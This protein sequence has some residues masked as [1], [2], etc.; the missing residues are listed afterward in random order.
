MAAL[1]VLSRRLL[2]AA[3]SPTNKSTVTSAL[4]PLGDLEWNMYSAPW[5]HLVLI[6]K[7][8]EDGAWKIRSEDRKLAMGLVEE[9]LAVQLGLDVYDE[10]QMDSL[11][12][13]WK[14]L[15]YNV[16]SDESIDD[17]WNEIIHGYY[18]DGNF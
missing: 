14:E 11:K 6:V 12:A 7:D 5:R 17:L 2:N 18:L 4:K 13:R 1:M 9:I 15:L 10:Q 16:P 3:G 8:E